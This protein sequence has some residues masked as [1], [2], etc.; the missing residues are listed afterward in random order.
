MAVGIYMYVLLYTIHS[1]EPTFN[2]NLTIR[3]IEIGD[4][5][6][7]TNRI[8]SQSIANWQTRQS[9]GQTNSI[10]QKKHAPT[11]YLEY[12]VN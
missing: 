8:V 5:F 9:A 2:V 4:L 10:N 7:V 12:N 11:F 3:Q 1:G 6:C